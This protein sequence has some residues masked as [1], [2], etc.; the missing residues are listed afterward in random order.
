MA[1]N[2]T[3]TRKATLRNKA[4][5]HMRPAKMIVERAGR[6]ASDVAI[7]KAGE[8]KVDAKNLLDM[9]ILAAGQGVVL[10]IAATGKDATAA[11]DAMAELVE[12]G[13]DEE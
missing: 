7:G 11:A 6:F 9:M 13:F 1:G 2:D 3:A 4:G 5:L 8:A 12:S 10:E